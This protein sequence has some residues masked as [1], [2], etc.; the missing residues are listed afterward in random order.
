MRAGPNPS[1][2]PSP[3]PAPPWRCESGSPGVPGTGVI[4]REQPTRAGRGGRS[5]CCAACGSSI[6][7]ERARIEVSG[8]HRHTF[9]NPHGFVFEI[10][11]FGE[12]PGCAGL[13]P[14]EAFFSWFPGY[15]WRVVVCRGCGV[16]LGWSYGDPVD[17]WGLVL[18]RLCEHEDHEGEGE[19]G[20]DAP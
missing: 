8:S 7:T 1:P 2:G 11:C 14:A 6:T 16:H 4:T 17:F 3:A 10:G 20:D 19:A 5:L 12:A 18:D 9:V 15:A 13:G